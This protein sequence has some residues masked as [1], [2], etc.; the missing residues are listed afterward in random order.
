MGTGG[1]GQSCDPSFA[2]PTDRDLRVG[3]SDSCVEGYHCDRDRAVCVPVSPIDPCKGGE[4]LCTN[5][6]CRQELAGTDPSSGAILI[7]EVCQP[8]SDGACALID[9]DGLSPY[10]PPGSRCDATY[11]CATFLL[12][13]EACNAPDDRC[14]DGFTCG[15]S[16][17]CEL[18]INRQGGFDC[19]RYIPCGHPGETCCFCATC[20]RNFNCGAGAICDGLTQ[21]CSAG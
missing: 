1:P 6:Y 10:C 16:K 14:A 15:A 2:W 9:A 19:A 3:W 17:T 18:G 11:Q 21:K 7:R 5:G 13:G 12:P 8:L 4:Q 20:S